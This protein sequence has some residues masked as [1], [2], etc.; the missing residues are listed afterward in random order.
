MPGFVRRLNDK[1][2]VCCDGRDDG[3]VDVA[4]HGSVLDHHDVHLALLD[5]SPEYSRQF[6]V[7]SL[8]VRFGSCDVVD[9][10]GQCFDHRV[11][12]ADYH[13]AY[14]AEAG[15]HAVFV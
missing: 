10:S 12:A 4:L 15:V 2:V 5:P 3:D 14:V 11:V 9:D 1:V 13:S 8:E 7:S 6:R